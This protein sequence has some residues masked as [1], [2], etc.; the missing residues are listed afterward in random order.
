MWWSTRDKYLESVEVLQYRGGDQIRSNDSNPYSRWTGLVRAATCNC[1]LH[2]ISRL[3]CHPPNNTHTGLQRVQ[4]ALSFGAA[5]Y[6]LRLP[7]RYLCWN[8]GKRF[9]WV[10]YIFSAGNLRVVLTLNYYI[11][12]IV[13]LLTTLVL[14][15]LYQ[16][17]PQHL[18]EMRRRSIYYLFG[19]EGAERSLWQWVGG[20]STKQ[21]L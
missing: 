12:T 20:S 9:S 5:G 7:S 10:S 6:G 1:N 8:L 16:Y 13:L 15:G 3:S 2:F 18:V 4:S 17:M 11:V 21:E 19:Q 14:T